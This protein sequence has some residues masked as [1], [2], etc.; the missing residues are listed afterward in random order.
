L[1]L[2]CGLRCGPK[3]KNATRRFSFAYDALQL[4]QSFLYAPLFQSAQQNARGIAN[5]VGDLWV[6]LTAAKLIDGLSQKI[7]DL[8]RAS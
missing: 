2:I 1:S 4:C 7:R 5:C 3:F 6:E 8:L